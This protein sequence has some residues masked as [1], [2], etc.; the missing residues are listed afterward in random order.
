M[1]IH[2]IFLLW[3]SSFATALPPPPAGTVAG[4]L[5]TL[6]RVFSRD[7]S[8][9]FSVSLNPGAACARV[10]SG[11]GGAQPLRVTA[12][13]AVDA[14]A[15]VAQYARETFN[16]SFSWAH[17]GGS[18][19]G[20]MPPP[21]V[22]LPP[23]A[24][25]ELTLCRAINYTYYQNVVQA[26][27]SNAW[28]NA[29]RWQA[30]VDWMAVHGVNIALAYGGQEALFREVYL[31]LGLNDTQLGYFF[32]GPAFLAWSRGQ[33]QAGVGGPLPAWW[34]K[35][36]LELNQ[37]IVVMMNAVGVAPVLPFFQGNVPAGLHA[38]FPS[39]NISDGWLDVFDPL[40][41]TIQ[42]A[43]MTKL[44][45]AYPNATSFYEGDG[46]FATGR[47]PWG[48]DG[49]SFGGAKSW[50][51]DAAVVAPNPDALA[52]STAAYKSIAKH[53]PDATWVYQ[54]WIWR[55]FESDADL[56]YLQGWLGGAP[57]GHLF[58][59]DQTA[60]RV[61][62]WT[63]FGNFSFSGQPFAW[64]SMNDMGGNVGLVGA[65]EWIADGVAAAAAGGGALAGVGID[66]EGINTM[67]AYW[68]YVFATTWGAPAAPA[69]WL[70]DFG[71]RRCGRDVAGVRDAYAALA[72]TVF[73]PKQP[74]DEH[75]LIYC[76]T[77]YPLR[78]GGNSWDNEKSMLRPSVYP[79]AAL[80]RVW[81]LLLAAA[82]TCAAPVIYDTI[83]I[84]REFLSLFPCVAAHDALN[85]ATTRP[86]VAAA[87]A[88]I[89]EVL[90]DLDALL[91]SVDGFSTGAWIA[92][93]RAL[94]VSAGASPAD[95]DLL[96]WNARSQISTW[97]PTPPTPDNH[98]YDYANKQWAGMTRD[99]YLRR[100][101]LLAA[102][103]DAA[104]AA[105]VRVDAQAY[106]NDL[107]ALGLAWT[108]ATTP[109]YPAVPVGDA[110]ALAQAAYDR[111]AA[112]DVLANV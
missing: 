53:D 40:F 72:T 34:Y 103:V 51:A 60:E 6:S 16:A 93:A 35:Q 86:A 33:G 1:K 2:L 87:N 58:L 74:N 39:A 111:Y 37:G 44:L 23:P 41:S 89:V 13:T 14:V 32:N 50:A 38:L 67:P 84:A 59:L 69:E 21:G 96:E 56:A 19:L 82:P 62:I 9:A 48:S 29:T 63:K 88:S 22:P 108:T 70:A 17:A 5:A 105:K 10:V 45:A 112:A 90:T 91:A 47:P 55:G 36:Q 26:S 97:F 100:Y 3:L 104:I 106:A 24:G 12:R 27:Y 66:P 68:E 8:S 7:A 18:S 64:L 80:A 25:G 54:S 57:P 73:S 46:L 65:L 11:G 99:Y 31:A 71:V 52:R 92:D 85:D 30:E 4:A 107:G 98:L 28:W 101:T 15:A 79:A 49:G 61:P 43:Y 77:A 95:G 94:G 75:H 78:G 110:L 42:D 102:R 76:G 109:V 20:S 83:D 81:S